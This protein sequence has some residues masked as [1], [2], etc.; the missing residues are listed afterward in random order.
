MTV[1]NALATQLPLLTHAGHE[2]IPSAI[3]SPVRA[4]FGTEQRAPAL[5]E[6]IYAARSDF[7]QREK[8]EMFSSQ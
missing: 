2:I 3:R 6:S 7:A 4:G 8:R 1:E 5:R